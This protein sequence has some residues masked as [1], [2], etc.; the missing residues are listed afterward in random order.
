MKPPIPASWGA[1]PP[2]CPHLQRPPSR[3][4]SLVE[5]LTSLAIFSIVLVAMGEMVG[6]VLNQLRIGEARFS[7]FQESQA[8]FDSITRRLSTCELN[9]YYDFQYPGSPPDTSAVPTRY[10]LE[11]DLH[12]VSGPATSGPNALLS[13]GSHPGHAIFFHGTFGLTDNPAWSELGTL[14]NSW[15]YYLEFGDDDGQRAGFLN[16]GSTSPRRH[17]FRLKELQVPAE[18]LRTYAAGLN[19]QTSAAGLYSWFRT[20]AAA[21]H[22]H[23]LAENVVALVVSPLSPVPETATTEKETGIAPTYFYDTRAYQH[24]ATSIALMQRTRHQLPPMLR[25]TLVALDE[26]SAQ[27]LAEESGS[28]MPNLHPSGI[29]QDATKFD[30]DLEQ[31]ESALT[32]RN[33]RFRTFSTTI[34]LRN[35]RWNELP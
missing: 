15:G 13:A 6:A 4:F 25:V 19:N 31:F 8:A 32:D 20:A 12:F 22:S 14:L 16:A 2:L 1:K 34:R 7:Q 23:T 21:G 10:D 29:F 17:R 26:P 11:S 28:A 30:A 24:A 35:A 9:P 3:G 33:L 5:L 27:R 18:A